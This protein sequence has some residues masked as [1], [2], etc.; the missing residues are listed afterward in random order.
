MKIL[1]LLLSLALLTACSNRPGTAEMARQL[2]QSRLGNGGE[3]I[4][5]FSDFEKTNGFAEDERHYFADVRYTLTF[6]LSH[7][8]MAEQ[9]ANDTEASPFEALG[10]GLGLAALQMQ[11]GNFQR[12]DSIEQQEKVEFIKTEKGWR[13][14]D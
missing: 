13:L 7:E 8:E 2:E 14:R 3:N 1:P 5:A 11:Y 9:I 12:G 4:F 10:A 6:K